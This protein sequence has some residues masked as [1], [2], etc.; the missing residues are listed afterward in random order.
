ME[1]LGTRREAHLRES[2]I[3]KGAWRD[4]VIYAIL[5]KEWKGREDE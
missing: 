5:A 3:I 1:R 2:H 4:E